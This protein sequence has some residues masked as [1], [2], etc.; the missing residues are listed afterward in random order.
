VVNAAWRRYGTVNSLGL[1]ALTAG[2][3]SSRQGDDR[4]LA[5]VKD[6]LVGTVA[7]TGLATAV[8]GVRFSRQAPGG[9][10][11]LEDGDTAAPEAGGTARRNKRSL[12]VLGTVNALSEVG[13]VAVSAALSD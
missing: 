12:T 5:R 7:V 3:A 13:L 6:V 2:W 11:A 8:E 10:V 4:L 9:A 1:A